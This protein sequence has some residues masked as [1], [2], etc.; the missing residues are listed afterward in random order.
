[1]SG[2]T[3]QHVLLSRHPS[4]LKPPPLSAMQH[5]AR[6]FRLLRDPGASNCC[7]LGF[8]CSHGQVQHV[9]VRVR[10]TKAICKVRVHYAMVVI[11]NRVE[12]RGGRG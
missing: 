2:H 8:T 4:P 7:V 10:Q 11:A 1:M 12:L 9:G 5:R 3:L 6:D